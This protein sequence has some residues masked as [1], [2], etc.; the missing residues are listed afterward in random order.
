ME[1][2]ADRLQTE[3]AEARLLARRAEGEKIVKQTERKVA[4]LIRFA[5][6]FGYPENLVRAV[7]GHYS[8]W[9]PKLKLTKDLLNQMYPIIIQN[10]GETADKYALWD[11]VFA[12]VKSA[13]NFPKHIQ[14]ATIESLVK[15]IKDKNI[16]GTNLLDKV[17]GGTT[18]FFIENNEKIK[19]TLHWPI[20]DTLREQS[21]Q[22][23][24]YLLTDDQRLYIFEVL[25][26]ELKLV[27]SPE[28][29]TPE[30]KIAKLLG[31]SDR[32]VYQWKRKAEQNRS[33]KF[34]ATTKSQAEERIPNPINASKM[35]VQLR[36]INPKKTAI[37]L[38]ELKTEVYDTFF[39]LGKIVCE[40]KLDK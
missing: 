3:K 11:E 27:L 17:L 12:G 25:Y 31:V 29:L 9:Y 15:V 18:K 37:I 10:L 20:D 34:D 39:Q 19:L 8:F 5:A 28:D 35:I 6:K 38:N 24:S 21:I 13:E 32:V 16:D 14:S 1:V 4:E 7:Y 2:E 26:Q 30:R 23:A 22:R 40:E 36:N 33:L